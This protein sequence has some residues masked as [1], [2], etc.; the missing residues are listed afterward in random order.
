MAPLPYPAGHPEL[1]GTGM[2]G[3]NPG[4]IMAASK[5]PDEAFQFLQWVETLQPTLAFAN[6]IN[7]VP[8]LKAAVTSPQ[9]DPNPS[10]RRFVQWAQG[11]KINV[12]PVISVQNELA[13][14]MTQIEDLVLH[15]KMTP[16]DGL[17]KLTKDIQSKLGGSSVP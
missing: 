15:G 12:F 14:E 13:T 4:M 8:Q 9:L 10:F 2:A 1:A 3:G 7:N 6:A 16:T 17:N 5:H 11:P